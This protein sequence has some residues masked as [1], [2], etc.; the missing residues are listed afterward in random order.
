MTK[1]ELIFLLK[2]RT[3]IK[4]SVYQ[5]KGKGKQN[6]IAHLLCGRRSAMHLKS[7]V[8]LILPISPLGRCY[9]S[10]LADEKISCP[11]L[12][13]QHIA[14]PGFNPCLLTLETL[15]FLPTPKDYKDNTICQK[16]HASLLPMHLNIHYLHQC[17][18]PATFLCYT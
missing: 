15:L 14:E 2:I 8:S 6:L 12:H 11:C 3:Y 17:S 7:I 4:R 13:R 10:Y 16:N 5:E 18:P 9:Y 1:T